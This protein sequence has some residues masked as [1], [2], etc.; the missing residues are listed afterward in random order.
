M[1]QGKTSSYSLM[2]KPRFLRPKF[3]VQFPVGVP[4]A[5]SLMEEQLAYIQSMGVRFSLRLLQY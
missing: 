4:K 1:A 2:V 3:W 5:Y